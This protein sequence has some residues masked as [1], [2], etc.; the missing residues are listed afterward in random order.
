MTGGHGRAGRY[1]KLTSTHVHTAT[2]DRSPGR[3][4]RPIAWRE[5]LPVR[6]WFATPPGRYADLGD[7]QVDQRLEHVILLRDD[8]LSPSSPQFFAQRVQLN[9][10]HLLRTSAVVCCPQAPGAPPCAR[11][12]QMSHWHTAV[13]KLLPNAP[14]RHR[15]ASTATSPSGKIDAHRHR[16]RPKPWREHKLYR[17]DQAHTARTRGRWGCTWPRGRR[18]V[19]ICASAGDDS[20]VEFTLAPWSSTCRTRCSNMAWWILD[21]ELNASAEQDERRLL[22]NAQ[23]VLRIAP[24]RHRQ[25]DIKCWHDHIG[26]RQDSAGRA[27]WWCS[28]RI[29]GLWD[30]L[31][32]GQFEREIDR[33]VR[34]TARRWACTQ[35][36]QC[37]V[38]AQKRLLGRSKIRLIAHTAALRRSNR[39]SRAT[40]ST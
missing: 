3:R 11:R 5:T 30:G 34:E 4:V 17:R 31:R 15:V 14:H 10:R 1:R 25:T 8:K 38:S 6:S 27:G 35:D 22:P 28:T 19:G 18:Q 32:R 40:D 26:N 7:N 20:L 39:H 12:S 24:T 36:Q 16:I 37:L 29:D 13:L 21:A 2:Q 23:A 9:Q 33:Q